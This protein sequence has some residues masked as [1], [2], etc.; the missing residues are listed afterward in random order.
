MKSRAE[1]KQTAKAAL[2]AHYG[3]SIGIYLLYML[4]VSVASSFVVGSILVLPLYVG[5]LFVYLM[6]YKNENPSLDIMFTSALQENYGRKLGGML[7]MTLYTFLWTLLFIIPGIVKSYSYAMTPY[8]LA[9]YT[10]VD[11]SSAI[12]LSRRIMNGRKVDLFVVDLSFI[13]W[14]LLNVLTFGILGIFYV[15]P[16]I[17][18][19]KAG[20]F[21]EYVAD[22]LANGRITEA[23]L[24]IVQASDTVTAE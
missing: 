24:G 15:F 11:A 20:C 9:K 12:T 5:M 8:I 19:T 16:Y 21:D 1:I 13:G 17:E 4:I 3:L 7:L 18:L 22:A 6:M 23:D 10:N 2:S 14:Q